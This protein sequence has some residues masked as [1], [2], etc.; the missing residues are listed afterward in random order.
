M[1]KLLFFSLVFLCIG[2]CGS[3]TDYENIF[4]LSV[5]PSSAAAVPAARRTCVDIYSVDV[6]SKSAAESRIG[7][8]S[9]GITWTETGRDLYIVK[10]QLDLE[11]TVVGTKTDITDPDEIGNLFG[12]G[13]NTDVRIPAFGSTDA[14]KNAANLYRTDFKEFLV[15][16]TADS[17]ERACPL[18]FGG[19]SVP[20]DLQT[21]VGGFI[22]VVAIAQDAAN[23]QE[24]I[25]AVVPV[26]VIIDT[27]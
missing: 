19:L 26:K 10:I 3:G 16:G 25:R 12:V 5:S 11:N 15:A 22:R 23:N 13:A 24:V 1:M 20:D 9:F 14:T 8:S 7:F 2:S 6:D 17:T 4:I 18:A 21:I 27:K